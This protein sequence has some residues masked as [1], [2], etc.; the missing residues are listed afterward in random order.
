L[1]CL[2]YATGVTGAV[3]PCSVLSEVTATIV[4]YSMNSLVIFSFDFFETLLIPGLG[5][6]D[7]TMSRVFLAHLILP[8][9][10]FIFGFDHVNNLHF[11]V[12]ADEDEIDVK[13]VIRK[14]YLME[15]F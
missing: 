10:V 7:E 6:T 2:F 9:I 11:C 12:Y 13:F 14:E 15:F 5:L 4:G 1:V 3:M 8:S